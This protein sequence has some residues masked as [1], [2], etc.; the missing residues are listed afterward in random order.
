MKKS[1]MSEPFGRV[2]IRISDIN[3]SQLSNPK[4]PIAR[5]F[6][7]CKRRQLSFANRHTRKTGG[8]TV[9][10]EEGDPREDDEVEQNRAH[11]V[12]HGSNECHARLVTKPAS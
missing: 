12:A 11:P 1:F 10:L 4:S 8:W 6:H 7:Y 9:E 5:S 3:S 2:I